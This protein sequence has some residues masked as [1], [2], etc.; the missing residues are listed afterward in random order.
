[1]TTP[2]PSPQSGLT[3]EAEPEAT[4]VAPIPAPIPAPAVPEAKDD[5][6][7]APAAP[8]VSTLGGL[9]GIPALTIG[10]GSTVTAVSTAGMLAGPIP[11]VLMAGGLAATGAAF[12]VVRATRRTERP[13]TLA[14]RTPRQRS[15]GGGGQ[16][17][18]SSGGRSGLGVRSR[19]G[20]G[21]GG[22]G[23][24]RAGGALRSAAASGVRA[25]RAA[26]TRAGQIRSARA[27][28]D[29]SGPRR[30]RREQ[31]T[32]DRRRVADARRDRKAAQRHSA[33]SGAAS[34]PRKG[35][36]AG[37]AAK[38]GLRGLA[39]ALSR[40]SGGRHGKSNGAGTTAKRA[41]GLFGRRGAAGGA[42]GGSKPPRLERRRT[43]REGRRQARDEIRGGWVKAERARIQKRAAERMRK[44]ALRRA[45]GRLHARKALAALCAAPL[46]LLSM[47]LWPLCKVL[48]IP[49]PQWGRRLYRH[50][51]RA[52]M[53]DR[54][55]REIAAHD[56]HDQDQAA[57]ADATRAPLG[58]VDN[59][60]T[61]AATIT[62]TKGPDMSTSAFDFR[63]AAEAM[64]QQAQQAE[65]GGM[66]SVLAAFE[67][68][69]EAMQSI[70]ETM[71]V[72]ATKASD[73]MPLDPKVGDAIADLHKHLL[74][75]VGVAE[76]VS[77]TFRAAH[78]S[79]IRRH[80]DPR[81]AEHQWDTNAND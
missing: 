7:S 28:A 45:A 58:P 17:A 59:G 10:A 56:K 41:G 9:P 71:A 48:R 2:T 46:G 30:G 40:R 75:A 68:L 5:K 3:A 25:A 27:G 47:A 52:A 65:P 15:G 20:G 31:L 73:E 78:E 38:G 53:D 81:V 23:A 6:A 43:R 70:A 16:R 79:D 34:G 51:V 72:V 64:L 66:M 44:R 67:G 77:E 62:T 63:E 19:F 14:P 49:T 4:P 13:R 50:M 55:Q 11:A 39:G 76:Q 32:A 12:A 60:D 35:M 37:G 57:E 26:Q 42:T 29:R 36:G 24:R 80:E 21:A 33:A 8:E 18:A 69:P 74:A 1:M 22:G 61:T 54:V